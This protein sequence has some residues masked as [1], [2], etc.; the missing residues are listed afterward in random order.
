MLLTCQSLP[1][2]KTMIT[3]TIRKVMTP[4]SGLIKTGH[5]SFYNQTSQ[6]VDSDSCVYL[7]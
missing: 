1:N 2:D 3:L 7:T 5:H 4:D 6:C